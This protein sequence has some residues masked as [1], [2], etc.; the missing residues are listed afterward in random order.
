MRTGETKNKRKFAVVSLDGVDGDIDSM[1][2][3]PFGALVIA[4]DRTI[5]LKEYAKLAR[6]LMES[7][8]AWATLHAGKQTGKLHAVFDKAIVDYQLKQDRDA[9]MM[10]SG[11]HEDT[12]QEAIFDAVW[13]AKPTYGDGYAELLIL[14][15]GKDEDKL[16][17]KAEALAKSVAEE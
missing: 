12:L 8:C 14:V 15:V 1:P 13:L 6:R 3:A 9:E 16:A 2:A 4:A 5:P 11:E 10:T 7:G 17:E